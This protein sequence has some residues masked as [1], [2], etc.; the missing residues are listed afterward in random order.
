MI[1]S[2]TIFFIRQGGIY[3]FVNN[4]QIMNII[5]VQKGEGKKT[6]H[7]EACPKVTKKPSPAGKVARD[8][9]TD[10]ESVIL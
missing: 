3:S 5:F 2:T 10:E 6:G 1:H 4:H 8:S 9:V 7:A